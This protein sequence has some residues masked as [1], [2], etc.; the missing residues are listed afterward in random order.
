MGSPHLATAAELGQVTAGPI[1]SS[2]PFP[3]ALTGPGLQVITTAARVVD[4]NN[5][6]DE[7]HRSIEILAMS[8]EC[9]LEL[10]GSY[11]SLWDESK[12]DFATPV[13]FSSTTP[14]NVQK[15]FWLSR[16]SLEL[17]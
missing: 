10:D 2:V 11:I 8:P 14:S 15:V 16:L 13:F 3:N 9:T 6:R 12:N 4:G 5:Q 17:F 1:A 7:S